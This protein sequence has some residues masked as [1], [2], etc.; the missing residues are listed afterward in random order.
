MLRTALA[1]RSTGLPSL[2]TTRSPEMP[3]ARRLPAAEHLEEH[4]VDEEDDERRDR[5]QRQPEPPSANRPTSSADDEHALENQVDR[6][7]DQAR[8]GAG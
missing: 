8:A 2:R 1:R 6:P 3:L 7:G 5:E 4:V